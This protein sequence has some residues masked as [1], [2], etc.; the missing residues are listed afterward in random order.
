MPA[1]VTSIDEDAF[2]DSKEENCLEQLFVS[3]AIEDISGAEWVFGW[4]LKKIYIGKKVNTINVNMYGKGLEEITIS[5]ENQ[6]YKVEDNV[7]Y[8]KDGSKLLYCPKAKNG[9]VTICSG[10]SIVGED[11]LMLCQKVTDI[12]IPDTVKTVEKN[13]FSG[14]NEKVVFWVPDGTKEFYEA[15]LTSKTGFETGMSIK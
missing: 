13:A 3:D 9:T 15:L 8:T 6:F 14:V 7:V 4:N 1:T 11:S 5:P 2:Y 10:T 12:I